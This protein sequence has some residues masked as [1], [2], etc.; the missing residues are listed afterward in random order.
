MS[1]DKGDVIADEKWVLE[2]LAGVA[3]DPDWD[4]SFEAPL[5][6]QLDG[7]PSYMVGLLLGGVAGTWDE[8]FKAVFPVST[9]KE[10]R[11]LYEE[12]RLVRKR[13]RDQV[14][15]GLGGEHGLLVPMGRAGLVPLSYENLTEQV[16]YSF[17]PVDDEEARRILGLLEAYEAWMDNDELVW[18]VSRYVEYSFE[19]PFEAGRVSEI[20][21]WMTSREEFEA[22]LETEAQRRDYVQDQY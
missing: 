9:D 10:L 16:H 1:Q 11:S 20:K 19:I 3:E 15:H 5:R 18:Y 14:L 13:I 2:P 8:R 17:E 12:L 7:P 21:S 6:G 22:S 4:S